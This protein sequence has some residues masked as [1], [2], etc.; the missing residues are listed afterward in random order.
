MINLNSHTN[1]VKKERETVDGKDYVVIISTVI[2]KRYIPFDQY[3]TATDTKLASIEA[4]K[5]E[6]ENK[7]SV[8]KPI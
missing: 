3:Q 4:E 2:D 6:V 7:T 5:T 8:V 1:T